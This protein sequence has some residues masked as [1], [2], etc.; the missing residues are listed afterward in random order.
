MMDLEQNY[1]LIQIDMVGGSLLIQIDTVEDAMIW[2]SLYFWL[3]QKVQVVIGNIL[4]KVT[5]I[6]AN[7]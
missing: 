7:K 2:S 3:L 4:Q 5:C 6:I 1:L